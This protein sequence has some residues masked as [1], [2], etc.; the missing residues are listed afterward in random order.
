MVWAGSCCYEGFALII[1]GA[2]LSGSAVVECSLCCCY[3]NPCAASATCGTQ[4]MLCVVLRGILAF[5]A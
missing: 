5:N 2:S 4:G 1:Q 3:G